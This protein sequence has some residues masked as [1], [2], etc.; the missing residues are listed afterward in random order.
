MFLTILNK[1]KEFFIRIVKD[2]TFHSQIMIEKVK[3]VKKAVQNGTMQIA[4][5]S[6][7]QNV[8]K[9]E[10]VLGS[11]GVNVFSRAFAFGS[12]NYPFASANSSSKAWSIDD[13]TGNGIGVA[14]AFGDNAT[15]NLVTVGDGD[16]VIGKNKFKSYEN[17][18][19]ASG[20]VISIDLPYQLNLSD[21]LGN[22]F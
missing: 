7:L 13:S 3:Y 22:L 10:F 16:I 2:E 11:A 4:D 12:D 9:D 5:L 20:S 6:Y 21:F 8:S 14:Q 18:A 1:V 17:T 15:A 19:L